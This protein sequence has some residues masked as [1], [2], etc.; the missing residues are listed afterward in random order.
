MTGSDFD[1]EKGVGA[2]GFGTYI[3]P[4]VYAS[5]G[6]GLFDTGNVIRIRYDLSRGFGI[7]GTSGQRDSG[8]DLSYRFE[9]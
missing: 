1:Y 4:R 3:A 2:V 8:A 7:T 5:Y 6:I 9:N